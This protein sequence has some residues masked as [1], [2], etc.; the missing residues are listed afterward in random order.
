MLEIF[1]QFLWDCLGHQLHVYVC[2]IF[3]LLNIFL[4]RYI[5]ICPMTPSFNSTFSTVTI[6]MSS[7]CILVRSPSILISAVTIPVIKFSVPCLSMVTLL[8]VIAFLLPIFSAIPSTF[9]IASSKT[10]PVGDGFDGMLT[11]NS[12]AC[13][14]HPPSTLHLS[15][16]SFIVPTI[17]F[18][19]GVGARST[20]GPLSAGDNLTRPVGTPLF[21]S[22]LTL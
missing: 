13:G 10:K 12:H 20:C 17:S 2:Y 22:T 16:S 4:D 11:S 18:V 3:L 1:Q 7:N 9:L 8:S 15:V 5:Y 6:N 14:M 19:F 21:V